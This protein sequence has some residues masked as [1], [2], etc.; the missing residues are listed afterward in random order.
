MNFLFLFFFL[1]SFYSRFFFSFTFVLFPCCSQNPPPIFTTKTHECIFCR[2]LFKMSLY[3]RIC[4]FKMSGITSCSG[5]VAAKKSK[6]KKTKT[7]HELSSFLLNSTLIQHPP[8]SSPVTRRRKGHH[9][10]SLLSFTFLLF[11]FSVKQLVH[12]LCRPSLLPRETV[13]PKVRA[14]VGGLCSTNGF[15]LLKDPLNNGFSLL[16]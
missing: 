13:K 9:C 3:C 1:F 10:S 8:A 14:K 2:M 4:L 15:N 12:L 6:S 5:M 7:S 16:N 11:Y